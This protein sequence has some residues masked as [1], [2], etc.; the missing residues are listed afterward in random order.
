MATPSEHFAAFRQIDGLLREAA[1]AS[2]RVL[3]A[4]RSGPA[5]ADVGGHIEHSLDRLAW[6][7]GR[8]TFENLSTEELFRSAIASQV[9]E[10]RETDGAES[11]EALDRAQALVDAARRGNGLHIEGLA[12]VEPRRGVY[13][14]PLRLEVEQRLH[15][16][17]RPFMRWRNGAMLVLTQRD[18]QALRA[19]GDQVD[20]LFL[21]SDELLDLE[22]RN[23]PA[24][25]DVEL[26]QRLALARAAPDQVG[27]GRAEYRVRR[28]LR[29]STLLRNLRDRL[30]AEHPAAHRAL[31][32]ILAQQRT[33]LET[34]LHALPQTP[35]V[36]ADALNEAITLEQTLRALV[37]RWA[38]EPDIAG[39][40][41]RFRAVADAGTRLAD[42]QRHRP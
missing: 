26:A 6:L 18:L 3:A 1:A 17:R 21:D 36:V 37:T 28:L 33:V 2:A 13:V 4:H 22:Q 9:H 30:A 29:Q 20:V 38:A 5:A 24:G 23:D 41:L 19:E 25:L 35:S 42:L 31:L 10:A 7:H 27:D 34:A 8:G 14:E 16:T 11:T 39:F 32:P 40:G 12:P 15:K